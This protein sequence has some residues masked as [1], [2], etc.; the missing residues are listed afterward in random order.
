MSVVTIRL[1]EKDKKEME[2]LCGG[3][4]LSVSAFYTICTKQAIRVNGF[5][6]VPTLDPFF[7][8]NNLEALNRSEQQYKEGEYVSMTMDELK[9]LAD[10]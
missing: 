5:P 3:L 6:F 9:G 1:S 8:A 7:S 2:K 10:A 4:G